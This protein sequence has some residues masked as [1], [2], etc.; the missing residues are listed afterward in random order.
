M[1][2]FV[3]GFQETHLTNLDLQH[4]KFKQYSQIFS[5]TYNSKQRG[6][7]ILICKNIQFVNKTSI[8]D[9]EARYV[10]ITASINSTPFTFANNY[11]PN[12]DDPSFF[13][14]NVGIYLT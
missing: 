7:S 10:I 12:C 14:K 3:G 4:L 9:P 6:V 8:I 1:V 13:Q 11:G 2:F 5:A